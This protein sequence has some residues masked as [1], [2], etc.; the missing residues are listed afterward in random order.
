MARIGGVP[1][2]SNAIATMNSNT[3]FRLP[4]DLRLTREAMERY[5]RDRNDKIIVILHA[6]VNGHTGSWNFFFL[7]LRTLRLDVFV[8][9]CNLNAKYTLS[10]FVR[11]KMDV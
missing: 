3:M 6:K 8:G 5:L 9:T 2:A 10:Y 7:A 4:E 1:A 11:H